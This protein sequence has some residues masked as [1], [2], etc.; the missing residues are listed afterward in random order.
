MNRSLS[1]PILIIDDDD[2]DGDHIYERRPISSSFSEMTLPCKKRQLSNTNYSMNSSVV[3]HSKRQRTFVDSDAIL[4]DPND[5]VVETPES[6]AF[7]SFDWTIQPSKSM[8]PTISNGNNLLKHSIDRQNNQSIRKPT[9][10]PLPLPTQAATINRPSTQRGRPVKNSR[11]PPTIQHSLPQPIIPTK[12]SIPR[13]P[14][15]LSTPNLTAEA[16]RQILNGT[17]LFSAFHDSKY[18]R[19]NICKFKSVTRFVALFFFNKFIRLL[20]SSSTL[21]QH[22]FTHMF[23]CDHCSF[24]TYSYYQLSQHLFDKHHINLLND[25]TQTLNPK[26]FDLLYVTRCQDGPFALCMDSST[27]STTND[28]QQRTIISSANPAEQTQ[29]QSPKKKF[30]QSNE[31]LKTTPTSIFMKQRND[32]LLKKPSYSHSFTLEYNICRQQMIQKLNKTKIYS[33]PTSCSL[34]L[35]DEVANCLK[36]IVNQIIEQEDSQSSSSS[37]LVCVLPKDVLQAIFPQ[38]NILQSLNLKTKFRQTSDRSVDENSDYRF[39]LSSSD[40]NQNDQT[41]LST[42]HSTMTNGESIYTQ[43]RMEKLSLAQ[44][45]SHLFFKANT[46]S[47]KIKQKLV[48]TLFLFIETVPKMT[49]PSA[50]KNNNSL[51]SVPHVIV[52]D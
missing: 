1:P 11:I 45:N 49:R 44:D 34:R 22:M 50:D 48:L 43:T 20:F 18:Y 3:N 10:L 6:N 47:L 19:C 32:F 33:K 40:R 12:P 30:L 4:L 28:Q 24:Y 36:T 16:R 8:I 52:L 13:V 15:P 46:S 27:K 23:F 2:D 41:I 7:R 5:Y 25:V 31:H 9:P 21:L 42:L 17:G 14:H 29:N 35:I 26:S 38:E 51:S 37:S 39:I